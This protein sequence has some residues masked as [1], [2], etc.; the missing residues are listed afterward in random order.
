MV[1]INLALRRDSWSFVKK[2]SFGKKQINS[3]SFKSLYH[4]IKVLNKIVPVYLKLELL[5][6]AQDK[7][8]RKRDCG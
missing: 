3:V 7:K 6:T 8:E 5:S 1:S 2:L 4:N